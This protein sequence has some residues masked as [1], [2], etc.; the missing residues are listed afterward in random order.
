MNKRVIISSFAFSVFALLYVIIGSFSS[1]YASGETP[2]Y[3]STD[4]TISFNTNGGTSVSP[5][6][7]CVPMYRETISSNNLEKSSNMISRGSYWGMNDEYCQGKYAGDDPLSS[8]VTTRSGYTFGGWYYDSALTKYVYAE[9]IYQAYY[10]STTLHAR[11]I[12]NSCSSPGNRS[13]KLI[14]NT[15]GG[16]AIAT[17]NVCVGCSASSYGTFPTPVR[18]GYTFDKWKY[19][20]NA[21]DVI[22]EENVGTTT[23]NTIPAIPKYDSNG[24]LTGYEDVTVYASWK[25]SPAACSAYSKEPSLTIKYDLQYDGLIDTDVIEEPLKK[26]YMEEYYVHGYVRQNYKFDGW[27]YD[28]ALTKKQNIFVPMGYSYKN[29][30]YEFSGLRTLNNIKGIYNSNKCLTGYEDITLYAK[31]KPVTCNTTNIN[32]KIIFES[33]GGN[34]INDLTFCSSCV[35]Q[36]PVPVKE[37]YNFDG[38]YYDEQLNNKYYFTTTENLYFMGYMEDGCFTSYNDLILYAKW[39]EKTPECDLPQEYRVLEFNTMG[40]NTLNSINVCVGCAYDS[41][42]N[43]PTPTKNGFTFDGWYYDQGLTD[44]VPNGNTDVIPV[45][46]VFDEN[47]CMIGYSKVVVYAKWSIK[48]H[49]CDEFNGTSVLNFNTNGGTAINSISVCVGC[50]SNTYEAYPV[51]VK[52]GY[53]FIGWYYDSNFTNAVSGSNVGSIVRNPIYDS[54]GCIS[55]YDPVTIYAKWQKNAHVCSE[56]NGN[57]VLSFNTN[58]P[59]YNLEPVS[60][61][62]GCAENTYGNFPTPTRSGYTFDG[63]Y[64]DSGFTRKVIGNKVNTIPFVPTYDSYGCISGYAPVTIYAKWKVNDPVCNNL[65]GGTRKLIFNTNGG[66]TLNSIDVCVGC[67]ANTYSNFPTPTKNGYT[68]AGWFYD[69]G[70]TK[71]VMGDSVNTIP[72]EYLYDS[73]H[74]EVGYKDVTIYAKW[75]EIPPSCPSTSGG[76]RKLIFNTNGGSSINTIDV[77]VGCSSDTYSRF[78]IPVKIGYT[79]VGWYYNQSL[80]NKV[81]GQT[82]DTIPIVPTYDSEGCK[83]GYENVTVYAK[84][85]EEE[86]SCEEIDSASRILVFNTNGGNK[87]DS[88]NVCVGCQNNTYKKFPT[89]EKEG[90]TFGGWYY[91]SNFTKVVIGDNVNSIPVKYTYGNDDCPNGYKTVTIHAKWI[92]KEAVKECAELDNKYRTIVFNTNGG[93]I[94]NSVNV[95]VGCSSYDKFPTP[96]KDYNIFVGWYYDYD[97]K[98]PVTNTDSLNSIPTLE[99]YDSNNCLIGYEDINVYAKWQLNKKIGIK[100]VL[101]DIDGN[102]LAGYTVELH[103]EVKTAITNEKGEYSFEDVS[104]GLHTIIVRAPENTIVSYTQITVA[105]DSNS[106]YEHNIIGFNN[107]TNTEVIDLI[108]KPSLDLEVKYVNTINDTTIGNPK[109]GVVNS[110]IIIFGLLVI[111]IL[112]YYYV[113]SKKILIQI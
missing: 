70:F 40:G 21:S 72:V 56:I 92:S 4:I 12:P 51:P 60:V 10:E 53:T 109:T 11:W 102:V 19:F 33:N 50:A 94:I 1:A 14:F 107:N 84:W 29:I 103:S 27:Y 77:C 100:G 35:V 64:Y 24:C 85:I 44:A 74:C 48:A 54:Y 30:P 78:P 98:N 62:V 76:S 90:Y 26:N 41:Y 16:N 3:V 65:E 68:F 7:Y 39:T 73:D 69:S 18:T 42:S 25:G 87:I 58:V 67:A 52:E 45:E 8:V 34:Q 6:S 31:W 28:S 22:D 59:N 89:P 43:F 9:Q 82:V 20:Y 32:K 71:A 106:D 93:N 61:C 80:T 79:F 91:D 63:W 99:K 112:G 111:C 104:E 2:V 37:G 36:M 96:K 108:V 110:G 86:D 15:M 101:K 17:Q 113:N 46:P 57:V 105:Y 47:N 49:E 5:I 75:V 95:C 83:N 13:R 23:V 88:M 38:W 55:G 97:L 66:S 81:N